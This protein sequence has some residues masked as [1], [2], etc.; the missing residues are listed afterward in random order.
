VNRRVFLRHGLI[1][2]GVLAGVGLD[3]ARLLARTPPPKKRKKTP[4]F[5]PL[6]PDDHQLLMAYLMKHINTYAPRYSPDDREAGRQWLE[7]VA[8]TAS[9][10]QVREAARRTTLVLKAVGNPQPIPAKAQSAYDRVNLTLEK[11]FTPPEV[12]L[13]LDGLARTPTL[14]EI[15]ALALGL[16]SSQQFFQLG[17][18]SIY[19]PLADPFGYYSQVIALAYKR[20][21]LK[22]KRG[23]GKEK[24]TKDRIA[25]KII[26]S[27][28]A[29]AILGA[30]G[31][32][33]QWGLDYAFGNGP[34]TITVGTTTVTLPGPDRES[35]IR[36][37][38]IA[39]GT[40]A[41]A[42]V[43]IY[44]ALKLSVSDTAGH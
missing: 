31:A 23:G 28:I 35:Q 8:A 17:R 22:V 20:G 37:G 25:S 2:V 39:G 19:D 32:G 5:P 24:E 21:Q 1:G 26:K 27:D 16:S 18:G 4:T 36:D 38:A 15:P 3:A 10:P 6:S 11:A 30:L 44:K 33:A 34:G 41:S 13:T 7:S 9:S 40:L 12:G 14:T 43:V 29:G 42:S